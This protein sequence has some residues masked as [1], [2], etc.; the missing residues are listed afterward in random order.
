MPSI[1][2]TKKILLANYSDKVIY[3]DDLEDLVQ[4]IYEKI[5]IES[6]KI[7][8]SKLILE[9]ISHFN[10][11]E[12]DFKNKNNCF[13][14]LNGT[15]KTTILRS[16]ALALI[17]N[18]HKNLIHKNVKN[19]LKIYG[20][21]NHIID[22]KSGK[23]TLKY[24]VNDKE[25]INYVEFNLTS[26]NDIEVKYVKDPNFDILHGDFIKSLIIGF[27]QNRG[28]L[29]ISENDLKQRSE[30][31]LPHIN[32]LIP[33]INNEGDNR[34]KTFSTWII[35]LD[36]KANKIENEALKNNNTNIYIKE[37]DII[38]KIFVILSEIVEENISF[39]EVINN[40]DVWISTNSNPEGI[41][42]ELVS[43]GFQS[44][45]GWIGFFLQRMAES[46]SE[47]KDFTKESA[48]CFVDELDIY[49]HPKWQR[50]LLSVLE[51]HFPNTQFITTTHSPLVIGNLKTEN[52]NVYRIEQDNVQQIFSYGKDI[53][54]ILFE[55]YGV[56]KRPDE[57]QVFIDDLYRE[58]ENENI[59]EA[60]N[61][62]DNLK[63]LISGSDPDIIEAEAMLF[64]LED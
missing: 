3:Y 53:N 14:G 37:K 7:T 12:I 58:I 57:I 23:I 9:N 28:I 34:L 42:L 13:I 56:E 30:V 64:T 62:L 52:T 6:P 41:S 50:N 51:K 21:N 36:V 61:I 40:N 43:Q 25:F 15:G 46:Y 20:L 35:N 5:N 18:E 27:T 2:E 59:S 49:I 19:F 44:I 47:S 11:L 39:K 8:I 33:L 26:D 24:N 4:K 45:I 17:G 38:N 31:Q 55:A 32:D 29:K 54:S 48:I 63:T 16:I 1:L 22:R 10:N 60:K